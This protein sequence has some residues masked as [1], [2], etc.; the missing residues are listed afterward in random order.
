MLLLKLFYSYLKL[1][2]SFPPFPLPAM[3]SLALV[4][5]ENYAATGRNEMIAE[6]MNHT[7][8]SA[9]SLVNYDLQTITFRSKLGFV[10]TYKSSTDMPWVTPGLVVRPS[11]A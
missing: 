6:S 2:F 9:H 4:C 1:D 8:L 5:V 10:A 11:R 3:W 7:W